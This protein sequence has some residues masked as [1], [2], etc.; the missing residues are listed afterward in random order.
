MQEPNPFEPL[1]PV[2]ARPEAVMSRGQGSWIWDEGGKRY[3]DF[4]QGWAVNCLGHA[5]PLIR[6]ALAEQSAR[7]LS[8]SPAL[9]NRPQ[10][11]LAELLAG[12]SGLGRVF[13]CN[14]GTEANE[15]AIKLARKWG[16]V[17]RQGAFEIITAQNAFHGR[18]LASMAASGKPGWDE[19]FPPNLPFAAGGRQ[20]KLPD[21]GARASGL[22]SSLPGGPGQGAAGG[23][24]AASGQRGIHPGFL[25]RAGTHPQRAAPGPIAFHARPERDPRGDRRHVRRAR[26][27][28]GSDGRRFRIAIPRRR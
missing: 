10:L 9:H 8:A 23:A 5:P 24:S 22:S 1:M 26:R 25:F 17:H 4:V 18:T 28:A 27:G 11:V 14:S 21:S 13:F 16:R 7:L 3:L 20:G 6:E 19:M 2:T 15:G 12:E